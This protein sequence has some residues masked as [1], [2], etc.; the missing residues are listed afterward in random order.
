VGLLSTLQHVLER[1]T[2]PVAFSAAGAGVLCVVVMMMIITFDVIARYVF[3]NPTMWGGEIASYLMIAIVF[4]GLGQNL[5][6]G[7]HIRIDI[8]TT[9]AA[10]RIRLVLEALAY[11]VGIV[12]T[13]MLF[14]GCW[15][16][17]QNFW[18]RQTTSDSP[19]MTELWLPMVPVLL[20]AGIFCLVAVSGFVTAFHALLTG[21]QIEPAE[22]QA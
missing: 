15:I 2:A 8:V 4:L 19:L 18:V 13:A 11:A 14:V 9:H 17:F 5:R 7:S 16:R 12:F 22:P 1:A 20:G 6:Q 3:N 10:P 21:H